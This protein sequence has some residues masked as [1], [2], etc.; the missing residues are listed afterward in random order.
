MFNPSW[1]MHNPLAQLHYLSCKE[2]AQ[3]LTINVSDMGLNPTAS[4]A[5]YF[6]LIRLFEKLGLF[7]DQILRS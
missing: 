6:A 2:V 1:A 7:E 4:W 5:F 3:L